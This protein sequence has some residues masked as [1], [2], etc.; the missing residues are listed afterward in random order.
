MII[1]LCLFI[2]DSRPTTP[3]HKQGGPGVGVRMPPRQHAKMAA[4]LNLGQSPQNERERL[5]QEKFKAMLAQSSIDLGKS[6]YMLTVFLKSK[7]PHWSLE[8]VAVILQV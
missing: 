5:Q 8:F 7:W 1:S 6:G 2:S 4:L 3:S